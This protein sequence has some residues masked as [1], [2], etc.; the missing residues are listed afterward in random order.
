[1]GTKTSTMTP[2]FAVNR[3]AREKR[4]PKHGDENT[5]SVKRQYIGMSC[6]KRIPKHGDEEKTCV[7]LIVGE[8]DYP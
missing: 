2:T 6:E 7:V 3:V 4:I 8:T 5:S 1:M